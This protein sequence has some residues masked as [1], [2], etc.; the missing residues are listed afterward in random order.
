[1]VCQ[2]RFLKKKNGRHP[3]ATITAI[4]SKSIP[5]PPQIQSTR[6]KKLGVLITANFRLIGKR[7]IEWV[8]PYLFLLYILECNLSKI[9]S[10]IIPNPNPSITPVKLLRRAVSIVE[11]NLC[12]I[13]MP[14][15]ARKIKNRPNKIG[16]FVFLIISLIKICRCVFFA[17]RLVFLSIN[18]ILIDQLAKQIERGL[19]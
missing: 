9:C 17:L 3:W 6:Q 1:M 8:L 14:P 12:I 5:I 2:W 7:T 15:T 18:I 4:Q 19:G 13:K 11:F 16:C 10:N